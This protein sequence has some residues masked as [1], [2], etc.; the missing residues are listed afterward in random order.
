MKVVYYI[1]ADEP[2]VG[3]KNF[4]D[5]LNERREHVKKEFNAIKVFID[6]IG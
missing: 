1:R 4:T 5:W 2:E 6:V 3:D